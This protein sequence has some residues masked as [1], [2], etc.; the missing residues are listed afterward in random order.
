MDKTAYRL[1]DGLENG[2]YVSMEAV[3]ALYRLEQTGHRFDLILLQTRSQT[4]PSRVKSPMIYI[5]RPTARP[6][7]LPAPL[8]GSR[9]HRYRLSLLSD[10]AYR[11]SGSADPTELSTRFRD[12]LDK[13][14]VRKLLKSMPRELYTFKRAGYFQSFDLDVTKGVERG[15]IAQRV[16]NTKRPEEAARYDPL[17]IVI[18]I[19]GLFLVLMGLVW[20][21]TARNSVLAIDEAIA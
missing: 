4:T 5:K 17:R 1:S 7:P 9:V 6:L 10:R 19:E 14:T 20:A 18:P 16:P 13:Q 15:F 8:T 21:G 12:H 3:D 2:L 11:L